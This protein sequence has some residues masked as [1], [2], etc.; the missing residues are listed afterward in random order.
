MEFL[1]NRELFEEEVNDLR[2]IFAECKKNNVDLYISSYGLDFIK[3]HIAHWRNSEVAEKKVKDLKN[4]WKIKE[5]KV[6]KY[7]AAARF[8]TIKDLNS[9]I[10]V[11]LAQ[12]KN[13]GVI[14]THQPENFRGSGVINILSL[15]DFQ[16]RQKLESL[17]DKNTRERPTVLSISSV[18]EIFLLNKIYYQ[19]SYSAN[20]GKQ[21]NTSP[22]SN[23]NSIQNTH[24][25]SAFDD[26]LKIRA[27]TKELQHPLASSRNLTLS[28]LEEVSKQMQA[29]LATPMTL[30]QSYEQ[31]LAF[32]KVAKP[33]NFSQISGLSSLGEVSKQIQASLVTPMKLI[34]SYE[35]QL[36]ALA[37]A[38]KP[39]NFS[40]ISGLSSL[41][42]VSKQIQ[43]SLVTPM[44]LS[45]SYE[46]QLSA[47]AEAAKQRQ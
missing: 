31:L 42:E 19:P 5:L 14:L 23:V 33:A 1:I 32:A 8:S 38:A 7:V 34:R 27:K 22:F 37:E 45:R 40:K 4:K 18:E 46:Q 6:F 35:Q 39:L 25:P 17:L 24:L 26:A 13:I 2:E 11:I 41:E 30:T 16:E 3:T 28:F 29:S 12:K 21:E 10:E 43:A 47:L 15:N 9:A 44:K 36:S 20:V